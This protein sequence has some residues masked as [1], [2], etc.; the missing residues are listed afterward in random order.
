MKKVILT[1]I[2][3]LLGVTVTNAQVTVKFQVNMGVQTYN[4]VFTPGSDSIFVSGSFQHAASG[5]Q[6]SSDWTGLKMAPASAGDSMYV[7]TVTLDDSVKG[8]DFEYKFVLNNSGWES[9]NNRTFTAPATTSGNLD[10]PAVYYN[11][12]TTRVAP[13]TTPPVK[14]YVKFVADLSGIFGTGQGY[15]DAA[16]D[17]IT[18][19]GLDWGTTSNYVSGNKVLHQDA[20]TPTQYETDTIVVSGQVGDSASWKFRASPFANFVNSG[21]D[22]LSDPPFAQTNRWYHFVSDSTNLITLPT[23]VPAITPAQPPIT[24]DVTLIFRMDMSGTITDAHNN[25]TIPYD[26]IQFVGLRSGLVGLGDWTS[27]NWNPSDTASNQLHMRVLLDNGQNGDVTAGDKIWSTTVVIPSGTNGGH[28]DYK[29]GVY[30]GTACDTAN[31]GSSIMDNEAA[32]GVN[33]NFTL[34][35]NDMII[36]NSWGIITAVEK[37]NGAATPVTFKLSQNYP[38]PFNPSTIIQYNLPKSGLVSLKIYDILG[39]EVATLVN[40]QQVA[41]A[42]KVTFDASKLASGVYIYRIISGNFISTKKMMLLK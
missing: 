42:Y 9:V 8:H 20:F 25:Y 41:G 12:D 40:D 34:T 32:F 30:Y 29:Y 26:S 18:I 22:N 7:L 35:N 4:G 36:N 13:P 6:N 16:T 39:R 10:I 28:I 23:I 38:N 19:Y 11:D 24:R 5:A 14:N 33:N 37:D 31:G 15:F 17:S 21:W 1:V 2:L 27:G 3:L